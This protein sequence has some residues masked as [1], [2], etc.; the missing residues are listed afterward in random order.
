MMPRV[1][2][3]LRAFRCDESTGRSAAPFD[4]RDCSVGN[5]VFAGLSCAHGRDFNRAVDEYCR[6]PGL[7]PGLIENVTDGTQR[8]PGRARRVGRLLAQRRSDR[9]RPRQNRIKASS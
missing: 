9:R 2:E 1:A 4:F 8:A 5:L 3:R 7:P 6:A